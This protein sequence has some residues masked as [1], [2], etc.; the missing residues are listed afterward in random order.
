LDLWS[1]GHAL[2]G[3]A[4]MGVIRRGSPREVGECPQG[5]EQRARRSYLMLLDTIYVVAMGLTVELLDM[6]LVIACICVSMTCG[7]SNV[8]RPGF[9]MFVRPGPGWKREG[10]GVGGE[11]EGA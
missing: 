7:V 3:S 2:P 1:P 8:V 4:S 5:E 11:S 6:R 10:L 9:I